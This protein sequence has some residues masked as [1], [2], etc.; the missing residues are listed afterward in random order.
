M[1]LIPDDA[2]T[3]TKHRMWGW[4]ITTDIYTPV[5]DPY[6]RHASEIETLPLQWQPIST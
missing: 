1:I 3:I 6:V 2:Y 4:C 5:Y